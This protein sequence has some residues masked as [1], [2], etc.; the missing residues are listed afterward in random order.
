MRLLVRLDQY[1]ADANG[2][3]AVAQRLLHR[4]AR[5]DDG[6]AA[7]GLEKLHAL[8]GAPGGRRHGARL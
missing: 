3:T 5:A 4:L 6:D 8:V 2:A 7:V 1:L